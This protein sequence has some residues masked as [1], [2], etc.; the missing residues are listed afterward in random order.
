M[1]IKHTPKTTKISSAGDSSFCLYN[2]IT[3]MAMKRVGKS[4]NKMCLIYSIAR[5]YFWMI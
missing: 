4:T 1:S 3:P 5:K 2:T